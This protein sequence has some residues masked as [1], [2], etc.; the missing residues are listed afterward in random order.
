M[1]ESFPILLVCL[2]VIILKAE[3]IKVNYRRGL[4]VF[5]RNDGEYGWLEILDTT[6][7]QPEEIVFGNFSD[8]GGTSIRKETGET[9]DVFIEDFC[10]LKMAIQNIS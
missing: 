4:A 3:I 5:L 1:R 2:G 10:S 9:V 8:L 6:D 7:L